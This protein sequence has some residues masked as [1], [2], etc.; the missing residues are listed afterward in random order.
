MRSPVSV[1]GDAAPL[2]TAVVKGYKIPELI[3]S[4]S[5]N[6]KVNTF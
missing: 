5:P 3:G 1:K 2:D 6:A 4:L